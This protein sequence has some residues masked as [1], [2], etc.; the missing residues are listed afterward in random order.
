MMPQPLPPTL[1]GLRR[2]IAAGERTVTE[3]LQIQQ[4]I[5]SE[6]GQ[7]WRCII[8]E[9]STKPVADHSLPLAGVGLAHKD[10]FAMQGRLPHCG[11]LTPQARAGAT[12]TVMRRLSQ[13]GSEPLAALAMAEFA[14]GVTGENPNLPLPVNPVDALAAV[15]GSS[16]GSGV[17]VAA[18]LCYGSLGTDTAGS[19]RIPAATCGVLGLKPTRSLL[20]TLGCHPLASSLDTIGVIARSALDAAH[21]FAAT[22]TSTQR[23]RL[24]PNLIPLAGS[25][26]AHD[27]DQSQKSLPSP[28]RWRIATC[29]SH[30]QSAFSLGAH[31]APILHE[32]ADAYADKAAVKAV[33][34]GSMPELIRC[35]NVL[36]HVESAAVHAAAL[37]GE[38]PELSDI[39][40]SVALAGAAIPAVWYHDALTR[41]RMHTDEF[42][43]TY[44]RDHDIFI[45]P[46]LPQGVPDWADVLT[47][48]DS[49]QSR[50]L[51]GLF[52][53]T[54]FVN[55]LGLPAIVFPIGQDHRGR[56]V[57]VQ[58]IARPYAEASLLAFAYE[59]ER[60]RFGEN[61]FIPCPPAMQP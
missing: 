20:P 36:L 43:N 35:T 46:M 17:A 58:A 41:R 61:G 16:S 53:W 38:A 26:S 39:T 30:P 51:L 29:F 27:W 50:A 6:Q 31:H 33:E 44:L 52:S 25:L 28:A 12:T 54:S 8:H 15:G 13:A 2:Q 5:L 7:Q 24:L 42:I 56:P 4:H 14:S 19:V 9:F 10:I 37:R 34:F 21:I 11:T 57:C 59:T 18:G 40:R 47:E 55:Y 1:V 60:E 49:F 45:T 22:L 23:K 32:F 3:A 48:S